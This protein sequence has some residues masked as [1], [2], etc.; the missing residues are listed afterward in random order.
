MKYVRVD[1]NYIVRIDRGEEVINSLT[2]LCKIQHITLG[3]VSA[4]GAADYVKIGLYDVEKKK[5]NSIEL[6]GQM[7]ITSLIGNI[8]TKDNEPYL[9]LH[10]NVCDD[11]MK[12]LGG[13][14][15][16]CRVSATCEIIITKIDSNIRRKYSDEI[17]L[18]LLD[19]EY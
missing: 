5:Y 11:K 3:S 10:I 13:H 2:E 18:N 7:E 19:I 14:L 4:I 15:N 9:H 17:G 1:N 6:S 12:V 8:T 16:E